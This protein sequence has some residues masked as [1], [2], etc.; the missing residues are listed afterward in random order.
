MK[1]RKGAKIGRDVLH[2]SHV[3][4]RSYEPQESLMLKLSKIVQET[5]ENIMSAQSESEILDALCHMDAM[6]KDFRDKHY[7]QMTSLQRY[8]YEELIRDAVAKM[9]ELAKRKLRMIPGREVL[10]W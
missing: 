1:C 5:R 9:E 8:E 7:G 3:L 6:F 2:T 4:K 10:H